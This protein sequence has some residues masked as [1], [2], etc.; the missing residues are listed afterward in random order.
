MKSVIT[1][2]LIFICHIVI[3]FYSL[4]NSIAIDQSNP[5]FNYLWIIFSFPTIIIYDLVSSYISIDLAL[6]SVLINSFFWSLCIKNI[7]KR[8]WLK[9]IK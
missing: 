3:S 2:L 9:N 8:I 4:M 1:F 5:Y 7:F 6:I